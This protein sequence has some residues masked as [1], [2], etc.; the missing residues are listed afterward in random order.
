MAALNEARW[1]CAERIMCCCSLT[2]TW[3]CVALKGVGISKYTFTKLM[4][5]ILMLLL[6]VANCSAKCGRVEQSQLALHLK[7]AKN[8]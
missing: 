5:A 2:R 4:Q 3:N 7:V 1:I 6:F 8:Q